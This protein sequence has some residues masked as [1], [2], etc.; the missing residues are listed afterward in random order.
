VATD[1]HTLSANQF[2]RASHST[3]AR[4]NEIDPDHSPLYVSE[5]SDEARPGHRAW[6]D[7]LVTGRPLLDA[8]LQAADALFPASYCRIETISGFARLTVRGRRVLLQRGQLPRA[9]TLRQARRRRSAPPTSPNTPPAPAGARILY[10]L[11]IG[12]DGR[13]ASGSGYASNSAWLRPSSMAR[14]SQVCARL[15]RIF[16]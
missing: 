3:P 6:A 10:F 1:A 7:R 16:L 8:E 4:V 11:G 9:S 12:S 5:A 15:V 2:C 13:A 14:L